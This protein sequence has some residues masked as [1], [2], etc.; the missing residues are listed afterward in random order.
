V[1][2]GAGNFAAVSDKGNIIIS[3]DG[4]TWTVAK[5]TGDSLT[6][7]AFGGAA[8]IAGGKLAGQNKVVVHASTDGENWKGYSDDMTGNWGDGEYIT[9]LCFGGDKFLAAVAVGRSSTAALRVCPVGGADIGKY[10]SGMQDLPSAA[11][12]YKMISAVYADNK[13]VVTGNS[14]TGESV[15][16]NSAD[17]ESWTAVPIPSD[18]KGVRSATFAN[19]GGVGANIAVGDFGNIY[20]YMNNSSWV[21]QGRATNRNLSTI[22][23]GNGVILAAGAKGAMLFSDA[24]P[25]SVRHASAPRAAT[26]SKG[27]LMSLSR[28]GRTS[29][30]TLSFAPDKAGSL[31]VYSLSGRQL[32]KTRL[33][34]GERSVRLPERAVSNGSVIVRYSGEGGRNVSQ[35]FQILK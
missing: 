31:A 4:E 25:T 13:F 24:P 18:I 32:Y 5:E 8:F 29:A 30:V 19:I 33:G 17:A 6:S 22:Y 2:F 34:A 15:V 28:A 20:A 26:S 9:S 21:P 35:R 12:G 7:V 3:A 27:G 23:S 14:P 16:L 1:T 11:A 10:W